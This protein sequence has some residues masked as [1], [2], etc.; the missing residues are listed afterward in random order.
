MQYLIYV[1][2]ASKLLSNSE[3]K[4]IL[5]ISREN[6]LRDNITG[7]LL[8]SEGTFMQ[9]LEGEEETLTA[10]FQRIENDPRHTGVVTLDTADVIGRLFPGQPL[11]FKTANAKQLNYFSDFSPK[12]NDFLRSENNFHPA[13][14]LL[15][16]FVESHGILT[17]LPVMSFCIPEIFNNL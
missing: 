7:M 5:Q 2:A 10:T 13:V 6:N 9:V 16:D 14:K 8:Y 15:K 11:G 17:L 12:S 3:I 1:S 4:K